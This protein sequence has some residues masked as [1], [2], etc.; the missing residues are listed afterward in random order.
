[1]EDWKE[2]IEDIIGW[3]GTVP[4]PPAIV[5]EEV[6]VEGSEE[7]EKEKTKEGV[8][9]G[10]GKEEEEEEGKGEGEEGEKEEGTEG[11]EEGELKARRV[12]ERTDADVTVEELCSDVER[13]S[14]DLSYAID[15]QDSKRAEQVSCDPPNFPP[16]FLVP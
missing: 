9:E 2:R 13:W 14:V 16:E 7:G 5:V 11:E 4:P 3:V 6:P 12:S 1:M 15:T 8:K 10:K